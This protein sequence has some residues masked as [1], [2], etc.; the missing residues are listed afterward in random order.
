MKKLDVDEKAMLRLELSQYVNNQPLLDKWLEELEG[1]IEYEERMHQ[2]YL[3]QLDAMDEKMR[4]T[5]EEDSLFAFQIYKARRQQAVDN[6]NT[7]WHFYRTSLVADF[8]NRF[9]LEGNPNS[10]RMQEILFQF[11]RHL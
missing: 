4:K 11:L 1:H 2:L 5:P 10:D 9:N 7:G 6:Y 3:N 8:I